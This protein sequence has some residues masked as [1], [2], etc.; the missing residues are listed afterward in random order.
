MNKN[1]LDMAKLMAMLSTM[2]KQDLDK[3]LKQ[4]SQVLNSKDKDKIID[5]LKSNMNK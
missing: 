2:D 1:N 5:A 4:L 3:G